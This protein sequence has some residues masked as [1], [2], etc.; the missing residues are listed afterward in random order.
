MGITWIEK[1]NIG[2]SWLTCVDL[3]PYE[4]CSALKCVECYYKDVLLTGFAAV[5]DL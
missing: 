1:V 2:G 3:C 4:I 5:S